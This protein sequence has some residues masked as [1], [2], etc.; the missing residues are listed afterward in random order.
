[1]QKIIIQPKTKL[2]RIRIKNPQEVWET[3]EKAW[4]M[5][6]TKKIDPIKYLR[7]TRRE[8]ERIL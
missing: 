8:W 1:M 4:G 5:W 7:K 3:W 6:K 2:F